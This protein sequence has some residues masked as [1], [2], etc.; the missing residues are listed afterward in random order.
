MSLGPTRPGQVDRAA[1][2][3]KEDTRDLEHLSHGW[4]NAYADLSKELVVS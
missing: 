2:W 1:R 3:L 4:A